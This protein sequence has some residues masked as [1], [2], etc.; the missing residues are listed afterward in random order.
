MSKKIFQFTTFLI[1]SFSLLPAGVLPVRASGEGLGGNSPRQG[2]GV[3][4]REVLYAPLSPPISEDAKRKLRKLAADTIP[5][6]NGVY[7]GVDVVG[8]ASSMFGSDTESVE[9]QADVNL[10]NRYFPVLEVG[11]SQTE[12]ESDYGTH[13]KTQAPYFRIGLNYKMKYRNRSENHLY[14]GARYAFSF[15]KY[16]LESLEVS[17]PIWGGTS[18]PNLSD[19]IWG[20]SVSFRV[21]GESSTAHWLELVGGIRV[22]V[23]ERFMMGWSIRYKQRFSVGKGMYSEPAYIPGFGESKKTNF[24]VTYSLIYKLPVGK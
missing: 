12:A 8:M 2:V 18:N 14:L 5:F 7:L 3:P 15:F 23:W 24:G 17:D 9:V 19:D 16:D 13:Y 4:E 21:K 1:L 6:F 20:G 11:Y 10:K 22:Q